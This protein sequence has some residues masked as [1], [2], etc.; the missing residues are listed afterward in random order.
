MKK[1]EDTVKEQFANEETTEKAGIGPRLWVLALAGVLGASA[2]CLVGAL[3]T[4]NFGAAFYK[5]LIGGAAAGI[6][7]AV[8]IGLVTG[9]MKTMS[10]GTAAKAAVMLAVLGVFFS[11][12]TMLVMNGRDM[13]API[14][15]F[16]NEIITMRAGDPEEVL[17]SNIVV[18]DNKDGDLKDQLTVVSF[19]YS[20]D[21]KSADVM[22]AVT[23]S[24]GNRTTAS[25]LIYVEG[26]PWPAE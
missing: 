6:V 11:A 7:L 22:Y 4:E 5:C 16:S 23:D 14:I 26:T 13:K 12:V 2:A 8:I 20:E 15:A 3:I 10:S 19:V 25:Q 9:K 21:G 24:S 17:Y 1:G 18:S